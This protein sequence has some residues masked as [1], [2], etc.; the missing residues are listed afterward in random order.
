MDRK[1]MLPYAILQ[2]LPPLILPPS[3]LFGQDEIS[4][5][6]RACGCAV[7]HLWTPGLGADAGQRLGFNHEHLHARDELDRP[8]DD[9]V[10]QCGQQTR[11]LGSYAYFLFP[12]FHC[13]FGLVDVTPGPP[14]CTLHDPDLTLT[15]L[16]ITIKNCG[17]LVG[18]IAARQ[19]AHHDE[20]L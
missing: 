19:Q 1:R 9:V 15:N 17:V 4:W 5:R 7:A 2:I 8:F 12:G 18:G 14:G 10:S 16:P 20:I 13:P 11:R 6:D 3:M